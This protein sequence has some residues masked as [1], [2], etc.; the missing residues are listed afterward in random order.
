M[1][2]RYVISTITDKLYH[3][4]PTCQVAKLVFTRSQCLG[5]LLEIGPEGSAHLRVLEADFH[6][7]LQHAQ[8][9]AHIVPG[10]GVVHTDH[11]AVF[12]QYQHG[13]GELDLS[14]GAGSSV[15]QD[16]EDLRRQTGRL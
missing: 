11:T 14:A 8:F 12:R 2:H 6:S 9:V 5:D 10:A 13:V 16:A 3:S 15:L 4:F 1:Q 7:R